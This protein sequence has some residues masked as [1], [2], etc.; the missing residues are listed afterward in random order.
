MQA[1]GKG[2]CQGVLGPGQDPWTSTVGLRPLIKLITQDFMEA[3]GDKD[4]YMTTDKT[5]VSAK[6]SS[7]SST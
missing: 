6:S 3:E 7:S 4:C 1:W 2:S 5:G